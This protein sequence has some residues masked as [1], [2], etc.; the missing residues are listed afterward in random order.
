MVRRLTPVVARLPH[1]AFLALLAHGRERPLAQSPE[2]ALY[3]LF[4]SFEVLNVLDSQR[5]QR[6][7]VH[8]FNQHPV[9][10]DTPSHRPVHAVRAQPRV[11]G[12]RRV[13]VV[14]PA[15]TRHHRTL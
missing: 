13:V 8:R 9:L 15:A 14:R 2:R 12:N 5:Q 4:A 11:A 6:R 1:P 7:V 3:R 10:P